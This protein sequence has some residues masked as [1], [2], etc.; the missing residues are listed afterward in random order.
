MGFDVDFAQVPVPHAVVYA[1]NQTENRVYKIQYAYDATTHTTSWVLAKDFILTGD[2][3]TDAKVAVALRNGLEKKYLF[4][5]NAFDG[6]NTTVDLETD[7]AV[8]PDKSLQSASE[9]AFL[10]PTSLATYSSETTRL[11]F[12]SNQQDGTVSIFN[13]DT[14]VFIQKLAVGQSP[15]RVAIQAPLDPTSLN[16]TIKSALSTAAPADFATAS[17]QTTLIRD[18][19]NV[20]QLQETNANPQG[21]LANIGTFQKNMNKWVVNE[22]LES[23]LNQ[24]VDLYRAAYVKDHPPASGQ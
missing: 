2:E 10:Y 5:T 8:G 6:T 15:F 21:V 3:P 24:S 18:W 1:V 19:E 4:I 23:D 7:Q 11:G 17:K 12:S 14:S 16:L 20:H 13:L 22:M 9:S